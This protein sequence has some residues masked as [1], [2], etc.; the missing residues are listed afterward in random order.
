MRSRKSSR[1]FLNMRGV[2]AIK[3]KEFWAG[4]RKV[5]DARMEAFWCDE[6][7][8]IAMRRLVAMDKE[9]RRLEVE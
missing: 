2:A 4:S 8:K 3:W 9:C 5:R 1:V 6:R 7:Y